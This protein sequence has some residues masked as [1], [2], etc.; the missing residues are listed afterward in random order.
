[1][2]RLE[3]F[4]HDVNHLKISQIKKELMSKHTKFIKGRGEQI[5]TANPFHKLAYDEHPID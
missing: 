5:N 1:M 4:G 2:I 3:I